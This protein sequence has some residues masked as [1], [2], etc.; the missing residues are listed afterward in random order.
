VV[1][2]WVKIRILNRIIQ[3]SDQLDDSWLSKVIWKIDLKVAQ[4]LLSLLCRFHN[5]YLTSTLQCY[6]KP[7]LWWSHE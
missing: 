3:Q 2:F 6:E 4:N 5:P 7:M 1:H